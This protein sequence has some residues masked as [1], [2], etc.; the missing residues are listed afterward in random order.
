MSES[1]ARNADPLTGGGA[2]QPSTS[3]MPLTPGLGAFGEASIMAQLKFS[4]MRSYL[5]F[6]VLKSVQVVGNKLK[7]FNSQLKDNTETEGLA[8]TD[9]DVNKLDDLLTKVQNIA[10]G[11]N[12][13]LAESDHE[14]L[15]KLVKF[16]VDKI[17]P[18]LDLCR[19]LALNKSAEKTLISAIG[20]QFDG[21][22]FVGEKLA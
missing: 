5:S 14:L 21:L 19:I 6:N 15:T 1:L 18:V 11:Q 7:E 9:E 16:P 17:F 3:S 13:V 12:V 2:Y 20:A 10:S 22:D 4:P 8:L